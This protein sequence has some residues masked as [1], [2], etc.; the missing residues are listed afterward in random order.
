MSIA[1]LLR[2][3]S[4]AIVGASGRPGNRFARPL[5]YLVRDGFEGG[6]FPVN[7]RYEELNGF[8]CYPSLTA[9]QSKVDLVCSMVP[10][11]ATPQVI[12][13]CVEIGADVAIIYASGFGEEGG[14][15][16]ER[17]LELTALARR[18]TLRLLGPNSLGVVHVKA[19]L[20]ATFSG[21]LESGMPP[22]GP[23]AYVGQSGAIGGSTMQLI[24]ELGGGISAFVS[25]GNQID[26]TTSEVARELLR[27]DDTQ[28]VCMYMESM[29]DGRQFLRVASEAQQAG[30]HLVVL[31]PP[32]SE[33]AVRAAASHTGAMTPIGAAF[34]LA[35]DEQG[36]T[37]VD[38]IGELARTAV[39]LCSGP[40]ASGSRVSIVTSSGGAGI[41][42]AECMSRQGLAFEALPVPLQERLRSRLPAYGSATNPVD[43]TAAAFSSAES[44]ELLKWTCLEVGASDCT[45]VLAIIL[46]NL[47]GDLATGI[48]KD[49]IEIRD[50]LRSNG[51]PLIVGW[52]AANES[53]SEA[54]AVLRSAGIPTTVSFKELA[55]M[56]KLLASP[57]RLVASTRVVSEVAHLDGGRDSDLFAG[58]RFLELPSSKL[59]ESVGIPQ[60]QNCVVKSRDEALDAV[61]DFVGPVAM[62]CVSP[63]L[64][65]K[66]DAGAVRLNVNKEDVSAV[67][68]ELCATVLGRPTLGS[69]DAIELQQM[70]G[71][72]FEALV[73]VSRM[74]STF[75]PVLT[76]GAGG[77]YTEIERDTAS[78]LL[79]VSR[80]N[81][82]DMLRS[83]RSAPKLF[84]YRGL[85]PL[86]VDGLVDVVV[87]L[88]DLAAQIGDDLLEIELNPVIVEGDAAYAVDVL[89][90]AKNSSGAPSREGATDADLT[91]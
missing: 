31:R 28:V 55:D 91:T 37:L 43:V 81:I 50:V 84:G 39:T 9:I 67:F 13:E 36:V 88:V 24:G 56:A 21:A 90:E 34:E 14:E 15:G 38:D 7:P 41:L 47:V 5:Q 64:L 66:T 75:P 22:G 83:L 69:T 82:I 89:L 73:S 23:I 42:A 85:P 74:S 68:D 20:A 53:I 51:T 60:P 3:E 77:I 63:N 30:K 25:T 12:Q 27:E 76:V 45:D 78:S 19:R 72:G 26:I 10:A 16:L 86:D 70:V 46:T 65:H 54:R 87:R 29:P 6:V 2:P 32:R 48:A 61:D 44:S 8:R 4:V 80:A 52:V 35:C 11:S 1:S 58:R 59:L 40:P 79:P 33:A 57:Q 18:G 49:L 62:K 71:P 17:E